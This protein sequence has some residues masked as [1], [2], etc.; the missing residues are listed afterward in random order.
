MADDTQKF[1]TK[2][3]NTANPYSY[4]SIRKDIDKT[5]S[6]TVFYSD[7][8]G[9][10][11]IS[12]DVEQTVQQT[13]GQMQQ[14]L[15]TQAADIFQTKQLAKANTELIGGYDERLENV[16]EHA[17]NSPIIGEFDGSWSNTEN[18]KDVEERLYDVENKVEE[19]DKAYGGIAKLNDLKQATIDANKALE[20]VTK[21][22]DELN[23][24]IDDV[25]QITDEVR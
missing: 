1:S 2:P 6:E 21:A 14:V 19:L 23:E 8:D 5:R 12:P 15:S 11:T 18:V 9:I 25:L 16:E 10:S 4:D 24:N 13:I 22:T 3:M 17:L 20:D 7:S